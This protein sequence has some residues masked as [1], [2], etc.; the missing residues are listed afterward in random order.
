MKGQ[1]PKCGRQFEQYDFEGVFL[2]S[3]C[4]DELLEKEGWMGIY[5]YLVSIGE[6][7]VPLREVS[8]G[9]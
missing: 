4:H 3:D 2:C 1:C 5:R 7:G 8:G 9:C 6:C